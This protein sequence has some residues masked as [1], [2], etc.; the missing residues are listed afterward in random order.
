MNV[1]FSVSA[2][3]RVTEEHRAARRTEILVAACRCFARDGFHA[4]SVNDIITESGL[5]AG[6]VYLYFKSKNE[7][8]AAV[9]DMTLASADELFADLLA[10]DAVPSP[11]QT[12]TFVIGGIM[13]RPVDHPL[14]GVDMSRLAL[15]A[16]AEA[17]RDPEI[18]DRIEH[19][20]RRL[21]QHYAEVVRRC[22]ATGLIDQDIDPEHVGAVLLGAVHAFALQRLLIPGT[23]SEQYLSGLR[24]LLAVTSRPAALASAPRH[25]RP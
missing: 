18:A 13:E 11:E 10:D 4:T 14:Y 20:M 3:P 9:V 22:Q 17:L 21:R 23:D 12:V 2:M 1:R 5:S 7:L 24:G 25:G 19:A 16:W 8:I 6:S 15:H